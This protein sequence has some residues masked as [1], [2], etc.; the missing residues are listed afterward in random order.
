MC[1]FFDDEEEL[2]DDGYIY[3]CDSCGEGFDS[4]EYVDESF[5]VPYGMEMVLKEEQ[6]AHCP[7]CGEEVSVY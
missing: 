7:Y 2:Q 6:S 1:S 4:P 5:W 3:H